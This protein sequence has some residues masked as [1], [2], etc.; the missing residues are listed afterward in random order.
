M[1]ID[2]EEFLS[3]APCVPS[4]N[5]HKA[6]DE[7]S[8]TGDESIQTDGGLLDLRLSTNFEEYDSDDDEDDSLG[9]TYTIDDFKFIRKL[10]SG[11]TA[12]VYQVLDKE[13]CAM[14]ALKVQRATEDALCE[15]DLHIPLKHKNICQMFD[16]FY[17]DGK[18]F[19]EHDDGAMDRG[20][21][22]ANTRYLCTMLESCDHGDLHD[23]I[24]EHV[25]VPETIAAK[26]RNSITFQV[27]PKRR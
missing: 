11:G 14:Y 8:I 7:P 13:S 2:A 19:M 3:K 20:E 16:Y 9:W 12:D 5:S 27:C 15:L 10:G 24:D 4:P 18:P 21:D 22:K 17:V 1:N 6:K 23:L 25:T 26:V